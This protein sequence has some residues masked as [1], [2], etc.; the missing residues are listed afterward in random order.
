MNTVVACVNLGVENEVVLATRTCT[1]LK[2]Y[3]RPSKP[4]LT[5][6]TTQIQHI[7]LYSSAGRKQFRNGLRIEKKLEA[8]WAEHVSLTFHSVLRKLNTE[9]SIGA[10]HQ[11]AVHLAKQFQ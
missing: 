5:L 4:Q 11:V 7:Y 6:A 9:P 8:Q 3:L 2:G 1:Q 10:S